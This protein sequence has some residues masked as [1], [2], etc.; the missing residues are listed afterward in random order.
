MKSLQIFLSNLAFMWYNPLGPVC[1]LQRQ[2]PYVI[3]QNFLKLKMRY[4]PVTQ[5]SEFAF[6]MVEKLK[7]FNNIW[8]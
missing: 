5:Q 1:V 6:C 4:F 3:E 2:D 7:F 8:H